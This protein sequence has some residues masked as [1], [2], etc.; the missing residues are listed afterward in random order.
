MGHLK[1]DHIKRLIT[2]TS[3]NIKRLSLYQKRAEKQRTH[4][5]GNLKGL[6]GKYSART[7]PNARLYTMFYQLLL[8]GLLDQIF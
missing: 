7:L 8:F 6:F 2:L 3:D 5:L 4:A 1:C